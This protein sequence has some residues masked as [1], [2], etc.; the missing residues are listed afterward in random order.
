MVAIH[1]EVPDEE[2]AEAFKPSKDS[3]EVKVIVATNAAESSITVPDVDHVSLELKIDQ[4]ALLKVPT[5][6]FKLARY[7]LH[8][9]GR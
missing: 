1:S 4:I 5:S 7:M 8:G 9:S 2:Q 6:T 3:R